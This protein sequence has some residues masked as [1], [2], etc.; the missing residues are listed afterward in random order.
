MITN[1]TTKTELASMQ[2]MCKNPFMRSK[3][4][5]FTPLLID[6]GYIFVFPKDV[7]AAIHMFFVFYPIDIMWL[8]ADKKILEFR[9]RVLPFTFATP[10][11]KSR[12]F[13]ELP[14]GT[15]K[16]TKTKVGDSISWD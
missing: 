11:V 13:I 5:M 2:T 8:S 7:L 3:G 16:E 12:Y 14:S 4:L 9:E 6:R 15:I 1:T 10:K